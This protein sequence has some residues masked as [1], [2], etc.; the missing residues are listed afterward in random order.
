VAH[1]LHVTLLTN[2]VVSVIVIFNKRSFR[3]SL[4]SKVSKSL[5]VE[6]RYTEYIVI[7]MFDGKQIN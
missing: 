4:I 7:P 3:S 2:A 5:Y 6:V 1:F